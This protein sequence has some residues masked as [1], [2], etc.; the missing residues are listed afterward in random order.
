[1]D[2]F[3]NDTKIPYFPVLDVVT[4]SSNTDS[5]YRYQTQNVYTSNWSRYLQGPKHTGSLDGSIE[6]GSPLHVINFLQ[7]V[8]ENVFQD[9]KFKYCSTICIMKKRRL[10]NFKNPYIKAVI[11]S[12]I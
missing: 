2:V 1:M 12:P 9:Q 5:G 4:Y 7:N 11:P 10:L 8:L 3:E 6:S